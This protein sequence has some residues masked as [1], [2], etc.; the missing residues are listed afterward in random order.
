VG[1]D[2]QNG[3]KQRVWRC[4]GPRYALFFITSCF[5]HTN[6]PFLGSIYIFKARGGLGLATTNK[7]GP[8]HVTTVAKE[9]PEPP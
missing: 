6:E 9:K 7:T 2:E 4:L 5:L 3:P 8:S 1:D